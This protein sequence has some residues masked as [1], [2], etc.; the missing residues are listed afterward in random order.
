MQREAFERALAHARTIEMAVAAWLMSRGARILPVYDYSGLG[1]GKAPKLTAFSATESLVTPDLLVARRGV[2]SWCEVKWKSHAFR[3]R[4]TNE[5][6]TG[7]DLRL[8]R[9]YRAVR[10][11]TGAR[12][13][14]VFAH[15][16]EN[17]VTCDELGRLEALSPRESRTGL[18]GHP[19]MINWPLRL[20]HPLAEYRE[21]I[22]ARAS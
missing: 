17:V 14:L 2:L 18:G 11:V 10:S 21:I 5:D 22:H 1:D 12:V 3:F 20:L 13:F 4:R 9:Q 7:I 16:H 19:P 6:E 8:W 15:E